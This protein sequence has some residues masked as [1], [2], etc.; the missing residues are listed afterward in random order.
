MVGHP[1]MGAEPR[2]IK[3]LA[4]IPGVGNLRIACLSPNGSIILNRGD[5]MSLVVAFSDDQDIDTNPSSITGSMLLA[6]A[7]NP[8]SADYA[9]STSSLEQAP[10]DI[11]DVYIKPLIKTAWAQYP[12]YNFYMPHTATPI[13]SGFQM[14]SPT[15]CGNTAYTQLINYHQWPPY[16]E[17]KETYHDTVGI[18]FN[19]FS[20]DFGK[21]F[22]WDL[23][24]NSY[25]L[26]DKSA[27]AKAVG[28]LHQAMAVLG[29]IDCEPKVAGIGLGFAAEG[30]VE[31]MFYE[32]KEFVIGDQES[33]KAIQ[34]NL[35]KSIPVASDITIDDQG[36]GHAILFDGLIIR[37]GRTSYHTNYGWGGKNNIWWDEGAVISVWDAQTGV[38]PALVPLPLEAGIEQTMQAGKTVEL[39]WFVAKQRVKETRFLNLYQQV[40]ESGTY[41][42]DCDI[43]PEVAEPRTWKVE[44]GAW[45]ACS[46]YPADF[47]LFNETF[48]PEAGTVLAFQEKHFCVDNYVS[49]QISVDGGDFTTLTTFGKS[50][51]NYWVDK[52]VPLGQYAG[53]SVNLKFLYTAPPLSSYYAAEQGGGIWIDNISIGQTQTQWWK[54]LLGS[55]KLVESK[56]QN[57]LSRH[58]I[59][60]GKGTYTMRGSITDNSGVEHRLGAPFILKIEDGKAPNDAKLKVRMKGNTLKFGTVKIHRSRSVDLVLENRGRAPLN[61]IRILSKGSHPA[62]LSFGPLRKSLAPGERIAVKVTFKPEKSGSRNGRIRILTANGGNVTVKTSGKALK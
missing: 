7:S 62:D 44:G 34:E 40:T 24:K 46:P 21:R 19:T 11:G 58:S 28:R 3:S 1:V 61:G 41:L 9:A 42:N 55:G 53:R 48:I 12:P 20:Y 59:N 23:M 49:L 25:E 52:S 51:Q 47:L 22:R 2:L 43:L 4:P 54:K 13:D 15:G 36:N 57:C 38:R 27:G 60:L 16:G 14:R 10:A 29:R 5:S 17:G 33:R 37:N 50:V 26:N 30:L 31:H 56:G 8:G 6:H 32:R 45:F 35:R 39:P 18:M